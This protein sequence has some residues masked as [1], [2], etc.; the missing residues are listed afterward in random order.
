MLIWLFCL[1]Q[2]VLNLKDLGLSELKIG[3]ID[4]LLENLL[5]GFY[6]DKRVSSHWH[7]SHVS[8]QSFFENKYGMLV[9]ILELTDDVYTILT[10]TMGQFFFEVFFFLNL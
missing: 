6:K 1:L 10:F 5:P 3:Q 8:A 2:P 9:I 7:T 4:Q